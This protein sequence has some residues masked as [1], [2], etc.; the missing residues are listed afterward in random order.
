[1]RN[2]FKLLIIIIVCASCSNRNRYMTQLMNE[3]KTTEDSISLVGN[4]ASYY[5]QRAKEEMH[6]GSD[7]L[8]WSKL[9]DSSTYF[10]GCSRALQEKLKSV[11]FSIDSLSKLK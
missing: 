8:T 7:S 2:H 4:Y 1:M 3:K 9:V 6:K 10:Y 11:E 5:M